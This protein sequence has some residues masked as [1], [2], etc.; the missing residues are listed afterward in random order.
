LLPVLVG[1]LATAFILFSAAC[2]SSVTHLY[3][4]HS[5]PPGLVGLGGRKVEFKI[6]GCRTLKERVMIEGAVA[7]ASFLWPFWGLKV[8]Q[9]ERLVSPFSFVWEQ[10]IRKI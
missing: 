4:L 6:E 7:S 9:R 10:D 5:L 3:D 8:E 1:F 2:L